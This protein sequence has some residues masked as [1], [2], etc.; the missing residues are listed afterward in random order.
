[1]RI[2]E[3]TL[4]RKKRE[5]R[6]NTGVQTAQCCVK[7]GV[8]E[9]YLFS[10]AVTWNIVFVGKTAKAGTLLWFRMH[11]VTPD[12]V[13]LFHLYGLLKLVDERRLM[14][15]VVVANRNHAINPRTVFSADV[16]FPSAFSFPFFL[17]SHP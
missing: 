14:A 9:K 10:L 4:L 15:C 7:T 16:D 12:T 8:T 17:Y 2:M 3:R 5:V 13:Q 6:A 11:R 1:M